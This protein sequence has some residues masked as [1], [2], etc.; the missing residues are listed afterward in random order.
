MAWLNLWAAREFG[1]DVAEATTNVMST[2]GMLAARC[3]YELLDPTIYSSV[4]Y[5]ESARVL[6]EWQSLVNNAQAVYV[7][8]DTATQ[9]AFFELVLHPCMAGHIV[10]EI[11]LTAGMQNT[12]AYE[13][14][15][16]ANKLA[17]D[18]LEFFGED[19][20]LTKRYHSLL[21]GKWNHILDQTHIGYNWWQQPMRNV[22]P[23][24][25][26]IQ[27][28]E[29]SLCGPLGVTAE[30]TNGS[31]P[32]DSIYNP[33]NSDSTQIMPPIDPYGPA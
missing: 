7:Q 33:V 24:L 5:N 15:Q 2:Y 26:Y 14:R 30:G 1:E 11:H 16:S 22:L 8:L 28:S 19:A 9:T 13:W 32:G 20:A 21:N 31:A 25:W 27:P 12:Y 29:I 17:Q 6:A 4:N 23:S 10:H 18:V 3:K